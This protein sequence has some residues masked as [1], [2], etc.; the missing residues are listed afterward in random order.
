M[1]NEN[2]VQTQISSSPKPVPT[3]RSTRP[4]FFFVVKNLSETN[5]LS[6]E[7]DENYYLKGFYFDDHYNTILKYLEDWT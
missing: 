7:S 2:L 6:F 1:P 3:T 5:A 4:Q